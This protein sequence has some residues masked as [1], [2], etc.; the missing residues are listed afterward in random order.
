MSVLITGGAG[1]IGVNLAKTLVQRGHSVVLID[2][3]SLGSKENLQYFDLLPEIEFITA[4]VN[5]LET[6]ISTLAKFHNRNAITEV[7]HLAANSDIP[8][9]IEDPSV[10]LMDTF[11]TTFNTLKLMH[12]FNIGRLIFASSSAIYGDMGDTPIR[13]HDGPLIP[14]SNY[15][16]M[17]LASEAAI[18]AACEKWLDQCFFFRFPNVVG[19]P[20]THGVIFDF[21]NKLRINPARLDVL[22]NGKQQKSYLHVS[23]L[24]NAMLFVCE[25]CKAKRQIFN[26]GQVDD[27]ASVRYIAEEVVRQFSPE[28]TIKFGVEEKGWIGD[29]PKFR[30]D[31][32]KLKSLGWR[33][34]FTSEQAISESVRQII[35]QFQR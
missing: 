7:W 8:A 12:Q 13:E 5:K 19:A 34:T 9:G 24:I 6:Y 23:D 33:P 21:I 35:T 29:V 14:I 16:A 28:A 31:V 17:K 27:G 15:G 2:N 18:F 3:L 20:A 11:L 22:G 26:V 4:D 30:Y 32:S 1:F 25:S 10:D